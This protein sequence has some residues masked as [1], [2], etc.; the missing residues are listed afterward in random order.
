MLEVAFTQYA[1][2]R[3]FAQQDALY[4]GR[5]IMQDTDASD[6]FYIVDLPAIFGVS[7]GVSASCAPASAS[8]LIVEN[9]AAQG[10]Q[11]RLLGRRVREIHQAL[12]DRYAGT[13]RRGSSATIVAARIDE[14]ECEL[15]NVGDS[16]GYLIRQGHGWQQLSHDHTVLNELLS[17]GDVCAEEGVE[18]AQMYDGL[19]HCLTADNE[20][21]D[22]SVHYW[23][24]DFG[25][26]DSLLLCSDG[27]HG[28][29]RDPQLQALYDPE[30]SVKQ[31][32]DIWRRAVISEGAP[33]NLSI[34]LVRRSRG[35]N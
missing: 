20:E 1:G 23:R 15:V 8:K 10:P 27:L 18:Y 17:G 34:V 13:K 2:S 35:Q 21:Y 22:F 31:Q 19:A 26:G 3:G 14:S 12:C 9:L 6:S 28:V 33:D 25:I 11:S 5:S 24:G 30:R 7:D 16:R 32:V 4:N 29:I